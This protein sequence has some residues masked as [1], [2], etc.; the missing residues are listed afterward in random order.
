VS[1]LFPPDVIE[2][3]RVFLAEIPGGLGAYS[4]SAGALVLRKQI[5]A[6]LEQRDGCPASPDELYLTVSGFACARQGGGE[7]RLFK[8]RVEMLTTTQQLSTVCSRSSSG[9]MGTAAVLVRQC[10]G[11]VW[12]LCRSQQAAQLCADTLM[13]VVPVAGWC[14]AWCPL[15]DR[16]VDSITNRCLPGAHP[17]V[18]TVQCNAVPVWGAA[19]AIR[20]GRRCRW[21]TAAYVT[22]GGAPEAHTLTK[23]LANEAC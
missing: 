12:W 23:G 11:Q 19:G 4:D 8:K 21:G 14:L 20:T 3:A 18:P 7:D 2:R 17:P 22:G 16:N 10:A 9:S 13:L 15:H 1:R 6:A 5:A